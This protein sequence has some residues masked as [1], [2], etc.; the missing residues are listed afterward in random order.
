MGTER[1]AQNREAWF[2]GPPAGARRVARLT[3]RIGALR[4]RT[5]AGEGI[6]AGDG[7]A[8]AHGDE[9]LRAGSGL[10]SKEL[11]LRRGVSVW[12]IEHG[13]AEGQEPARRSCKVAASAGKTI[14][15]N[16]WG[17]I[18]SGAGRGSTLVLAGLTLV[19]VIRFFTEVVPILP[20]PVQFIDIPIF[21]TIVGA[22]LIG[23][24]RRPEAS[25]ELKGQN[26]TPIIVLGFLFLVVCAAATF[27]N[28][29]RVD[30][31]P[32]LVFVYGFLGPLALAL[33]VYR[34]WPVGAALRLSKLLVAL[35]LVQIAVAMLI[36]L[37][38]YLTSQ[39]PDVI[40]GTFGENAYQLVFFL[41][42]LVALL[43]GIYS[44]EKYRMVVRFV[45]L[46]LLLVVAIIIFAQFRSLVPTMALTVVLLAWILSRSG[47]RGVVIS[48]LAAAT[49]FGTLAYAVQNIPALKF[50]TA[51]EQTRNDPTL[52]VK[53]RV[54]TLDTVGRLFGEDSRYAITG[55]GPGTYSSRAWSTFARTTSSETDVVGDYIVNFTGG[56][57]Y[58]TDV[59]DKYVLPQL[60]SLEVIDGSYAV[61]SPLSSYLSLL[62]ETGVLGFA[63]IAAAYAWALMS[64]L[65]MTLVSV[66]TATPGDPLPAL[67]C[68]STVAFFVLLQMAILENWLEVTRITFLCWILFAVVTKEFHCRA[69]GV[70]DPQLASQ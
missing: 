61:T 26:L 43:T 52:Y 20:R 59:A 44:F 15:V 2:R 14:P 17:E 58:S 68:A 35:G 13:E 42:V 24:R 16:V 65:R 53:K 37:P 46:L 9:S 21:I 55:T 1:P 48:A 23:P 38:R 18:V 64:S 67:L 19:I 51:L 29:S 41:L 66:C 39:N 33:A 4:Q 30:L 25:P 57:R 60:A 47:G 27:P 54:Q 49:L 34:L 63:L 31:A 12:T 40:S 56:R 36:D 22:A 7:P 8:R 5:P 69:R 45:P 50:G 10:T 32:A 62:A 6:G 3:Q 11:A 28:L 70:P